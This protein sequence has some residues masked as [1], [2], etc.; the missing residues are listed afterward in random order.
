AR[1]GYLAFPRM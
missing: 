1:P